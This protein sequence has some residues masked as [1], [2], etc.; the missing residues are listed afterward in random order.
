MTGLDTGFLRRVY[1]TSGVVG[2]IL[3]IY[4]W[5]Y[6]GFPGWLGFA[7]GAGLSLLSLRILEWTV[8]ALWSPEKTRAAKES[9]QA[10]GLRWLFMGMGLAKYLL[11]GLL[12]AGIVQAAEARALSLPAFVGGFA[13]V[14]AV[15]VLKVIGRTLFGDRNT[16]LSGQ[17]NRPEG[18]RE[19]SP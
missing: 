9:N 13:M 1:R 14:H 16:G 4:V 6:A 2:A 11:L 10:S 15:I 7:A 5:G 3:S 17:T 8:C 18:A 12:I 19:M